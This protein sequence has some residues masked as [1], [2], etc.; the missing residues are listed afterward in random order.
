METAAR[1][2]QAL[3]DRHETYMAESEEERRQLTATIESLAESKRNLEAENA[4]IVEEN[5]ELLA[6][7]EGLNNTISQ[8]DA[9]INS[10]SATLVAAQVE[11]RRLSSLAART[12]ELEAQLAE[13]ESG[14]VRLEQDLQTSKGEQSSAMSRWRQAELTIQNLNDQ[15]ERIE[16]EARDERERHVELMGRMERRRIVDS[17]LK[18]AAGRLKGAAAAASL[19]RNNAGNPVVSH[20]VR[21]ILQDNANLQAGIVELR[22]MLQVSNDEVQ[23]LRDQILLHQ[24]LSNGTTSPSAALDDELERSERRYS[25]EVHVHHHYH[26]PKKLGARKDRVPLRGKR[27]RS[28]I[29]SPVSGR[30]SG[31]AGAPP[32]FGHSPATS[33]S[34]P[35]SRSSQRWSLQSIATV[36]ALSSSPVSAYRASSIF[37]RMEA[38]YDSSR[39]TSPESAG[40]ASPRFTHGHKRDLSDFSSISF[41]DTPSRTYEQNRRTVLR[42]LPPADLEDDGRDEQPMRGLAPNVTEQME[43]QEPDGSS[44]IDGCFVPQVIVEETESAIMEEPPQVSSTAQ[45]SPDTDSAAT[46]VPT[47]DSPPHIRRSTSR[48]SLLSISGMDIHTLKERPSQLLLGSKNLAPSPHNRFATTALTSSTGPVTS[49][50]EAHASSTLSLSINEEHF[51]S[52]KLLS[53][54]AASATP[55]PSHAALERAAGFSKFVGGWKW[56]KWGVA[57]FPTRP[58]SSST[59]STTSSASSGPSGTS[60]YAARQQYATFPR[61]PGINQKGPIAGLRPPIR[62]PSTVHAKH[63]DQNLLEESLAE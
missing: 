42:N 18:G 50:T 16:K 41:G 47:F 8:S 17:E 4:R 58:G 51:S 27:T 59:E 7:L 39:P 3:L 53:G 43:P 61:M 44:L 54:L 6:Q 21:D 37:D 25:Q 31:I 63:V 5:R 20:F 55:P 57:P 29:A 52:Q 22:E 40:L 62:T 10:L 38:D 30:Q 9:Q 33:I 13:L 48:E 11:V 45:S 26:T 1:L 12:A 56:G 36:S 14:H 60:Q 46:D 15:I 28:A 24:P 2:G 49:T 23:N 34:T 19:G 35:H 32:S